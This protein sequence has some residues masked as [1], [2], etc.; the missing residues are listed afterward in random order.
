[1]LQDMLLI[2]TKEKTIFPGSAMR[3][4]LIFIGQ[5]SCCFN[6]VPAIV[7]ITSIVP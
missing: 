4:K 3:V 2:G 6:Y 7:S 5:E 1:V